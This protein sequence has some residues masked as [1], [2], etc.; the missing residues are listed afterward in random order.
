MLSDRPARVGLL[1]SELLAM[2]VDEVEGVV[3][4]GLTELSVIGGMLVER[5]KFAV[6]GSRLGLPD[7]SVL[8]VAVAEDCGRLLATEQRHALKEAVVLDVC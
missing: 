5:H 6:T 3:W 2:M 4:F 7:D 1:G 8:V